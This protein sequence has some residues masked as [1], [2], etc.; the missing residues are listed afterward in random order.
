MTTTC[1]A[2]AAAMCG[3][4]RSSACLHHST[5]QGHSLQPAGPSAWCSLAG[6]RELGRATVQDPQSWDKSISDPRS[7]EQCLGVG[8]PEWSVQRKGPPL[9]LVPPDII[10]CFYLSLSSAKNTF[11][12]RSM[13]LASGLRG[14]KRAPSSCSPPTRPCHVTVAPEPGLLHSASSLHTPLSRQPPRPCRRFWWL[15]DWVWDKVLGGQ[16]TGTG[17][18]SLLRPS[19]LSSPA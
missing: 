13:S 4:T 3:R 1:V 5:Q 2:A 6:Q 16:E 15:H 14:R 8:D 17:G 12:S 7:Q 10:K 18:R 19:A 9:R 11:E